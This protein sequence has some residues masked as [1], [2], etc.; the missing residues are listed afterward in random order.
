MAPAIN[1]RV[2]RSSTKILE[3]ASPVPVSAIGESRAGA[4]V[5]VR[6]S[7]GMEVELLCSIWAKRGAAIA[8]KTVNKWGVYPE[9]RLNPAENALRCTSID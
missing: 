7:L 9:I 4:F 2:I 1:S 8:N 6:V 5:V 3:T